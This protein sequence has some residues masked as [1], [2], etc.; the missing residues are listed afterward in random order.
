MYNQL[1]LSEKTKPN[2]ITKPIKSKSFSHKL[3]SNRKAKSHPINV[4]KK[5]IELISNETAPHSHRDLI[6]KMTRYQ[7]HKIN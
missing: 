4:R 1:M 3:I 7:C 6:T 2:V 5:R